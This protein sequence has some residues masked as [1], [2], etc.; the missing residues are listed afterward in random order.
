MRQEAGISL[1]V[2]AEETG[3]S[4]A[5]VQQHENGRSR[6]NAGQLK[7]YANILG[8]ELD[9]FFEPIPGE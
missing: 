7:L 8:A 1:D 6:I 5:L 9:D 4:R 3:F 2:M